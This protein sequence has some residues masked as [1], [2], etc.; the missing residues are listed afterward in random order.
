LNLILN[1]TFLV[2]WSSSFR[3]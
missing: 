2:I 1:Y 3:F